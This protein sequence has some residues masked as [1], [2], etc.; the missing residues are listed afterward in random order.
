MKRRKMSRGGSRRHFTRNAVRV[1]A[2]NIGPRFVMR[3][4]IRM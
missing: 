2:R 1:N 4:G 3:G